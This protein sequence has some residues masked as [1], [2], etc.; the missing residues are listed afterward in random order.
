M[1]NRDVFCLKVRRVMLRGDNS[2]LFWYGNFL[3]FFNR[4]FK[5]VHINWFSSKVPIKFKFVIARCVISI[6]VYPFCT[7]PCIRKRRS[8]HNELTSTRCQIK[9]IILDPLIT[10]RLEIRIW[11]NEHVRM[12]FVRLHVRITTVINTGQTLL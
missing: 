6:L 8:A 5:L 7:C 3:F 11:R 12:I 9:F 2:W 10:I 1:R 4:W